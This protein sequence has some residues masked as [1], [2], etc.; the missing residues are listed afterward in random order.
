MRKITKSDRARHDQ[1]VDLLVSGKRPDVV[2]SD[3]ILGDFRPDADHNNSVAGAF[4]T[5]SELAHEFCRNTRRPARKHRVVDL[6]SGIGQ[7]AYRYISC[8]EWEYRS[9]PE[10]W[11]CVSEIVCVEINPDFAAYIKTLMPHATVICGDVLDPELWNDIGYFDLAITNPPFGKLPCA[12]YDAPWMDAGPIEAR[13][14]HAALSRCN[15]VAAIVPSAMAGFEGSPQEKVLSSRHLKK[16]MA[17]FEDLENEWMGV[18]TKDY[19]DLWRGVK[20]R[21]ECVQFSC[22]NGCLE[23]PA[24]Y[25]SPDY[26]RLNIVKGET[27]QY[28]HSPNVVVTNAGLQHEMF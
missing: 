4:F 27:A 14:I 20:P 1:A 17:S 11:D 25:G 9:S 3:Q 16:L 6:C 24:D 7:L 26:S 2:Q 18:N 23:I 19:A 5:P 22:E 13:V 12:E 21:V 8:L 15:S 28:E 10:Y